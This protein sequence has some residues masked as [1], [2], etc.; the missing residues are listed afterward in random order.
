MHDAELCIQLITAKRPFMAHDAHR[1]SLAVHD[2]VVRR[3]T[4][5]FYGRSFESLRLKQVAPG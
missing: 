1:L 4:N 5:V 2:C 3:T